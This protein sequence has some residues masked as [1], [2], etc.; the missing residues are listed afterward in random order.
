MVPALGAE[1]GLEGNLVTLDFGSD[2]IVFRGG[3]NPYGTRFGLN[4]GYALNFDNILVV[5]ELSASYTMSLYKSNEEFHRGVG[6]IGSVSFRTVL[7]FGYDFGGKGALLFNVGADIGLR[8]KVAYITNSSDK[9]DSF[10]A[11]GL[12]YGASFLLPIDKCV[13]LRFGT[14]ITDVALAKDLKDAVY[15][16]IDKDYKDGG[17]GH[18]NMYNNTKIIRSYASLTFNF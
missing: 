7:G 10:S 5:P 9:K 6:G 1:A 8:E 3:S 11:V 17:I 12:T 13:N 16:T 2:A 18:A 4:Y 15:T 14:S